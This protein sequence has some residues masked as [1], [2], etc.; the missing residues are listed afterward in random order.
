MFSCIIQAK[1]LFKIRNTTTIMHEQMKAGIIIFKSGSNIWLQRQ[2]D[3]KAKAIKDLRDLLP[4]AKVDHRTVIGA[5]RTATE[6]RNVRK[7]YSRQDFGRH[8]GM[9]QRLYN[10]HSTSI[11][12]DWTSWLGQNHHHV[13]HSETLRAGPNYDLECRLFVLSTIQRNPKRESHSSDHCLSTRSSDLHVKIWDAFTRE[14]LRNLAITE[15]CGSFHSVNSAS[16]SSDGTR[17][18]LGT[19]YGSITIWNLP[20]STEVKEVLTG[21]TGKLRVP[22][23]CLSRNGTRIFYHNLDGSIGIRDIP[24]K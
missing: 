4:A 24:I 23:H 13:Y 18:L 20:T 14:L 11:L 9:G 10:R 7:K 12:V 17:I 16:F 2:E 1:T 3:Q 19:S 22:K 8:H 21:E 15:E 6:A 5:W